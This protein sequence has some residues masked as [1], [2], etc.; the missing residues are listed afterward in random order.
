M[1]QID[2][3]DHARDWI[4]NCTGSSVEKSCQRRMRM[5]VLREP[6]ISQSIQG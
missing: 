1:R 5:A 3:R 4:A 6:E 2:R